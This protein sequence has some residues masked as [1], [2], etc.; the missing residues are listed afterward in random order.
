VATDLRLTNAHVHF[1]PE[2]EDV[3]SF[4]ETVASTLLWYGIRRCRPGLRVEAPERDCFAPGTHQLLDEWERARSQVE[5]RLNAAAK[6]TTEHQPM[7]GRSAAFLSMFPGILDAIQNPKE[8]VL[9]FGPTGA[10]KERIYG[11]LERTS[12]DAAKCVTVDMARSEG[13]WVDSEI[14]GHVSGAFSGATTDHVGLVETVKGGTLVLDNVQNATSDLQAKILRLLE[15]RQ[16]YRRLGGNKIEHAD[17]RIVAGFSL[18]PRELVK[19]GKLLPDWIARFGIEIVVPTL[20]SRKVDI[21][22]LVET[23]ARGFGKERGVDVEPA[24]RCLLADYDTMSSWMQ[25][26]WAEHEGNVRGL[27]KEV[28]RYLRE[29]LAS[30]A[31]RPVNTTGETA[32]GDG[33]AAPA[34]VRDASEGEL[35]GESSHRGRGRPPAMADEELNAILLDAGR[36]GLDWD[37]LRAVLREHPSAGSMHR[38][39]VKGL[40]ERVRKH[41]DVFD[42]EIVEYV[43]NL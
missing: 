38:K 26:S 23:L 16:D 9:V 33:S 35:S 10:G 4:V 17:C 42:P 31:E 3:G 1:L 34:P 12:P 43:E 28:R 32:T 41:I 7:V 39:G 22:L 6:D 24:L 13:T 37:G 14:F 8:H 25:R 30:D 18:D 27:R 40:K 36:N 2:L 5:K 21:P 29:W 20:D 15:P 19:A 11:V